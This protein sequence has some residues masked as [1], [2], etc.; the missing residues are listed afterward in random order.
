MGGR[1][2]RGNPRPDAR[3]TPQDRGR[4]RKG[5]QRGRSDSDRH[6]IVGR[7]VAG[8]EE[9]PRWSTAATTWTIREGG[10]QRRTAPCVRDGKRAP[11]SERSAAE[12][13]LARAVSLF[14]GER[15][16]A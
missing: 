2:R 7:L 10:T 8:H 6:A 3:L 15:P 1:C 11:R 13:V 5:A 9:Q 16:T 12:H 4:T 14:D